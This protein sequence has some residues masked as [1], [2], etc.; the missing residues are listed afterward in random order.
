M[1]RNNG[2]GM[3]LRNTSLRDPIE[4][5]RSPPQKKMALLFIFT[6]VGGKIDE[7]NS[8]HRVHS[9]RRYPIFKGSLSTV[10]LQGKDT[11]GLIFFLT[12]HTGGFDT[13]GS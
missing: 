1:V 7:R 5:N 4:E 8:I 10:P 13:C 11:P 6:H 9:R 2:C 3:T 12:A